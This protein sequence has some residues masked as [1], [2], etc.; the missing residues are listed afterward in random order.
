M[1][2]VQSLLICTQHN[3]FQ[4]VIITNG[5][6]TYAVFTY[7][8]DDIN[9]VNG[10]NTV[11]GFNAGGTSYDNHPLS[12]GPDAGNIDCESYPP[13]LWNNVVYDVNPLGSN[14]SATPPFGGE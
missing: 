6:K 8:C 1:T 9:W 5:T 11:I 13:S 10:N 7:H 14:S 3:T 2:Q 4:A 12:A